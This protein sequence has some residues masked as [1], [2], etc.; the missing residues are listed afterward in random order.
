MNKSY[1]YIEVLCTDSEKFLL[2]SDLI[3]SFLLG[4]LCF[5]ALAIFKV[6]LRTKARARSYYLQ[7]ISI[8]ILVILNSSY[9][10]ISE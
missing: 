6:M 8:V 7:N 9:N 3:L 5:S 4:N 1:F 2:T 10:L